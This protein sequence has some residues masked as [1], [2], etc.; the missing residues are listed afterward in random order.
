MHQSWLWPVE[1][2]MVEQC[3][4]LQRGEAGVTLGPVPVCW[5]H[6][7]ALA[8][9]PLRAGPALV[10]LQGAGLGPSQACSEPFLRR[11]PLARPPRPSPARCRGIAPCP[12]FP[13]LLLCLLIYDHCRAARV[14]LSRL[15]RPWPAC[16][17][18]VSA[19]QAGRI[20]GRDPSPPCV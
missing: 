2:S 16:V 4:V 20:W 6:A 3:S 18:S 15:L 19:C 8:H 7:A 11:H 9:R 17:P 1:K 12:L 5:P 14:R 10:P 13:P